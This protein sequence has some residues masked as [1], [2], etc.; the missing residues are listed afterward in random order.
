MFLF[1]IRLHSFS[2]F[3]INRNCLLNRVYLLGLERI[4]FG[5]LYKYFGIL[6]KVYSILFSEIYFLDFYYVDWMLCRIFPDISTFFI[7]PFF[8]Y[9]AFI[10]AESL[11]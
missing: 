6:S 7:K 10:V 8:V 9:G 2:N 1:Q 11:I 4:S 5:W 3:F